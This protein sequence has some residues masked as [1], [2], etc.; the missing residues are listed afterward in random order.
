MPG[1]LGKGNAYARTAGER[2]CQVVLVKVSA[3]FN[4]GNAYARTLCERLCYIAFC[5]YKIN[6][7]SEVFIRYKILSINYSKHARTHTHT[8]THTDMYTHTH[9]HTHTHA[10]AHMS[11]LAIQSLIYTT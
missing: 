3:I 10:V 11:I 4:D 9:T 2:V 5:A 8:H 1:G 7:L 6:E